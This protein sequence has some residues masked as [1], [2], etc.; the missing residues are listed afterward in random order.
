VCVC[1]G[2]QLCRHTHRPSQ[3]PTCPRAAAS[4]NPSSVM[5]TSK[6]PPVPSS[7]LQHSGQTRPRHCCNLR[8]PFSRGGV[9]IRLAPPAKQPRLTTTN[10]L[11]MRSTLS[12]HGP[13]TGRAGAGWARQRGGGM[14]GRSADRLAS[15][16]PW[17][18]R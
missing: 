15:L 7:L 3:R 16:P 12:R 5:K 17:P 13:R 4:A 8:N 14:P 10:S 1:V 6:S 9:T 18:A 2:G 11:V